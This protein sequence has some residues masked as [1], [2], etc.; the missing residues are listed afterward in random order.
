MPRTKDERSR[1][2]AYR[3]YDSGDISLMEVGTARGLCQI[4][5]YLFG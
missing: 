5:G 1:E 3:L 4:H 2:K